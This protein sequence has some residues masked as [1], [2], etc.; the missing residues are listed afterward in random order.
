[1]VL[2]RSSSVKVTYAA[3]GCTVSAG[4]WWSSYDGTRHLVAGELDIDHLVPLEEAWTSGAAS[5]DHATRVAYANDLRPGHLVAVS[6]SLNRSKG[7][8][9]VAEWRP[10]APAA[11]CQY[12]VDWIQVKARCRLTVDTAERRALEDL[13]GTC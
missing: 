7:A 5:W 9:D 1:V 2:A 4:S 6:A 10:P 13:L 8:R 12:A 11:S 3:G